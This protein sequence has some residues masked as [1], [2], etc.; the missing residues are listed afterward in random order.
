[1][2]QLVVV[3]Q[4]PVAILVAVIAWAPVA[5]IYN[6]RTKNV[7]AKILIDNIFVKCL[8]IFKA[9]GDKYSAPYIS[10]EKATPSYVESTPL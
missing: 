7:S 2:S 1:M 8:F 3:L 4:L 10:D 6:D 9:A 5:H